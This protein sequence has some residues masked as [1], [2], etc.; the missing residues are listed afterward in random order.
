VYHRYGSGS[1]RRG[2][3]SGIRSIRPFV[4]EIVKEDEDH[5]AR[6]IRIRLDTEGDLL[7][8]LAVLR[9]AE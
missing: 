9:A 5:R 6:G 8:I 3:R 1:V 2:F 4:V 7:R